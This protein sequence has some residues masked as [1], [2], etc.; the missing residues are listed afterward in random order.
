MVFCVM[1]ELSFSTAARRDTVLADIQARIVGRPRW[2]V[3]HIEA[4]TDKAG[5]PAIHLELRFTSRL[6][7]EDLN[8]RIRNFATGQRAPLAGSWLRIHDCNHDEA[9]VQ[10]CTVAAERVW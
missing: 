8:S 5:N 9:D 1:A 3:D 10:L 7:Q 6:D 4:T 2:D